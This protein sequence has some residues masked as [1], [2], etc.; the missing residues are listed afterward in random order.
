M[1]QNALLKGYLLKLIKGLKILGR[2]GL[3]MKA[4]ETYLVDRRWP[5]LMIT[6]VVNKKEKSGVGTD[7]IRWI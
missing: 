7:I 6:V 3:F 5:G 4:Q 1:S 2:T